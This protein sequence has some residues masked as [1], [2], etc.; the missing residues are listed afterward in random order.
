MTELPRTI[1]DAAEWLRT[2]RITSVELTETLLARCHAA[3]DSLGA[4]IAITDSVALEA[5]RTAD[6]ELAEGMDRGPLHGIPLAVKD[7]IA[8]KDAPTTANSNVLN[9]DSEKRYDATVV[10]KL[11]LAGAVMMGKLGLYEFAVG[12]PDP[13]SGFPITRNPWDVSR[14]PGGS[15]SGPGAAVAAGLV[16][17][18]LGTDT[19]GS[20]R[21][22]AAYCGIAG[23]RPTFGR[24]SNNG[25]FPVAYSLDTIGPMARTARDC[26]LMLE[27]IAGYDPTDSSTVDIAVPDMT[28]DGAR[29]F[30]SIRVGLPNEHFFTV[31]ELDSEVKEAVLAAVRMMAAAG[32]EVVDVSVPYTAE[33]Y[34]AWWVTTFA[35]AYA[36]HEA[37]LRERPELYG[38]ST[39]QSILTGALLTAA[40]YVQA[41]RVRSLIKAECA[42]LFAHVDV[43]VVPCTIG[44]API[45]EDWDHFTTP[46]FTSLWSLIGYPALSLSCGFSNSGLPIGMQIVGKPF[47]ESMVL[48]VGEAYQQLTDWHAR[49]PHGMAGVD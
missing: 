9:G 20:I 3:Q 24:V 38:R 36:C 7:N 40:D 13:A 14:I 16:L 33:A 18:A 22:P 4:F 48:T 32:A 46:S 1:T 2:N 45:S 17:G 47:D 34:A 26:A 49:V 10:R 44:T 39:R 5:A 12:R 21:V 41:Q 42:D 8:T 27:A 6:A 28:T 25:C 29:S 15:S 37:H 30:T 23:L 19:G 35:E 11:R 31:G 43:L